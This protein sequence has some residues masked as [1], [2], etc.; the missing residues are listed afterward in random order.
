MAWAIV[1]G[2][3]GG[4]VAFVLTLKVIVGDNGETRALRKRLKFYGVESQSFSSGCLTELL[5]AQT[6]HLCLVEFPTETAMRAAIDK[7]AIEVR[8]VIFAKS[9]FTVSDDRDNASLSILE[10]HD[11]D[12]FRMEA[13]AASVDCRAAAGRNV[14][15][16]PSYGTQTMKPQRKMTFS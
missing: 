6:R 14:A 16:R 7:V 3:L 12:L 9:G 8:N 11:P 15:P 1:C 10:R 5:E 13:P 2:V 4:L